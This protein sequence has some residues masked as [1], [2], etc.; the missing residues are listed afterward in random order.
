MRSSRPYP[1]F[2]AP[3]PAPPSHRLLDVGLDLRHGQPA[4]AAPDERRQAR[5]LAQRPRP[6]RH[7][8]VGRDRFRE[9]RAH[10]G[11][12]HAKRLLGLRLPLTATTTGKGS[13]PRMSARSPSTSP[14]GRDTSRRI[15]WARLAQHAPRLGEVFRQDDL[16]DVTR[17]TPRRETRRSRLSSPMSSRP[18]AFTA[19]M[20]PPEAGICFEVI[21]DR[22]RQVLRMEPDRRGGQPG[23]GPRRRHPHRHLPGRSRSPPF[24]F[25]VGVTVES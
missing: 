12:G 23:R 5:R 17:M 22:G 4:D 2:P 7:E 8:L 18:T 19:R 20:L 25:I 3:G 11:E 13:S 6:R 16:P 10:S 9:E 1:G 24:L 15:A 14:S 21:A